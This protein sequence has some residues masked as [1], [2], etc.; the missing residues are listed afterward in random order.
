MNKILLIILFFAVVV[1]IALLA[2]V[3]LNNRNT[4]ILSHMSGGGENFRNLYE[5]SNLILNVKDVEKFNG[6]VG[7][8]IFSAGNLLPFD[9]LSSR[10]YEI[11]MQ[12]TPGKTEWSV[13][14][15]EQRKKTAG[16][17]LDLLSPKMKRIVDKLRDG[18]M[19]DIGSGDGT[20]GECLS[21]RNG[22][23]II[24]ADIGNF[25]R[26]EHSPDQF[27]Q[28]KPDEDIIL[29]NQ[30]DVAT[31]FHIFHHIKTREELE[32]RLRNINQLLKSRGILLFK[33]HDVSDSTK[34]IKV[35]L[36]HICYEI[37]EID[38]GLSQDQFDQWLNGYRLQLMSSAQFRNILNTSGFKFIDSTRP[39]AFDSS[40]YA[41]Y[42]KS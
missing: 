2:V 26:V 33:E 5:A 23:N 28:F 6:S 22:L 34:Y 13:G 35:C 3:K 14:D 18:Q 36:M 19:L 38:I 24:Y 21:Q 41:M 42:G 17:K 7:A 32:N 37:G 11:Y 39:T 25:L 27:I 10:L 30:V 12:R 8:A 9:T 16:Y 40:Y 31:C 15:L 1:I 20:V 29:P 4:V